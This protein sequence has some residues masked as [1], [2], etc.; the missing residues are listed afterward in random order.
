MPNSECIFFLSAFLL[1]TKFYSI[2][3]A[4]EVFLRYIKRK[5]FS[6]CKKLFW[7][8]RVSIILCICVCVWIFGNFSNKLLNLAFC[9]MLLF[10]W[11]WLTD[12]SLRRAVVVVS[13]D[14]CSLCVCVCVLRTS[15]SAYLY[16]RHEN[17]IEISDRCCD[18]NSKWY[19]TLL[20][21]V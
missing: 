21:K 8:F 10:R 11:V 7:H 19:W 15:N 6:E 1:N 12:W 13:L 20:F 3:C 16:I 9:W 5:T 14:K 17:N 4:R 18:S 2:V